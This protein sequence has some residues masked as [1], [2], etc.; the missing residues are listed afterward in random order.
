[1]MPIQMQLFK[2]QKVFQNFCSAFLKCRTNFEHFQKQK[3][4]HSWYVSEIMNFEKRS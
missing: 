3:D 4:P 2:K 1:M